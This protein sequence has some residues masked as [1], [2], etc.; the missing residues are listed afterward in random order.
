ML[1]DV[2]SPGVV[3][4]SGES[5]HL[6]AS[7][8]RQKRKDG[9]GKA[10]TSRT[11]HLPEVNGTVFH[12]SRIKG[13]TK[14]GLQPVAQPSILLA[15]GDYDPKPRSTA[16]ASF[17]LKYAS[18]PCD[19]SHRGMFR[20]REIWARI[21]SGAN[22]RTMLRASG[23][24][25]ITLAVAASQK[26]TPA[27]RARLFYRSGSQSGYCGRSSVGRVGDEKLFAGV[28]QHRQVCR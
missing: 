13:T 1:R 26:Q 23:L 4:A 24:S 16:D 9:H 11:G 17:S 5:E 14:Q 25:P 22:S 18:R 12:L 27:F 28:G 10:T 19:V 2:L 7:A 8:W 21:D 3:E 15:N 20:W 6:C